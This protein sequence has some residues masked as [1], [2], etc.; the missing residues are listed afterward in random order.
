MTLAPTGVILATALAASLGGV[1]AAET[2]RPM[3]AGTFTLNDWA[4]SVY[5]ID[6]NGSYEV[7]VT[8]ATLHGEERVPIRLTT[9]LEPGESK[10]VEVGSFDMS[11]NPAVLEIE[12]ADDELSA[13]LMPYAAA[14]SA[15]ATQ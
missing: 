12:R 11:E 2:L 8:L 1:A 14:H 9:E 15:P 10:T 13:T 3:Q 6:S 4:A 5:Y 7:V